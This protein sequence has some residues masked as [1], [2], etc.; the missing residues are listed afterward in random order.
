[1]AKKEKPKA[2]NIRA[3]KVAKALMENNGTSVSKAMREAGY[4][5]NYSKNPQTLTKSKTFQDWVEYYLPD[6]LVAEKH[7]ALLN[8]KDPLGEIDTQAV[9]SG[10][11]MAY[12][13]KGKYAPE[14]IEHKITAVE[15]IRY[16]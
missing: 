2:T 6:E 9:K 4:S 11:D 7:N 13:I 8:K 15:I 12:K 10:V 16:G 1:M 14:Q 3:K 5:K